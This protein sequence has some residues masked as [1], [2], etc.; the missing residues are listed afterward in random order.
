MTRT[1]IKGGTVVTATNTT[2]ADVLIEDDKIIA[3][4]GEAHGGFADTVAEAIVGTSIDRTIDATGKYVIPGAID[5]HT[6]FEL[7]FGG[8]FVSDSFETGTRAAAFGGTTSLVDFAVQ[9]KGERVMDGF[10]TWMQKAEG[11]CAIDYGFHMIVGDIN[12][13]SLKEMDAVVDEGVT[14]F[15]LFMAYP[16]VLYSDDGEIFRAMQQAAKNGTMIMMHAENGIAIDVLR[17][18][19]VVMGHTDPKYHTT[20][21]PPTTESEAAHRAL[22]LADLAGAPLYIVHMSAKE[23]VA[24]LTAARDRGQNAF[25]ETCPQYLFLNWEEHVS[26]PGFEGAKYVCSTPIRPAAEGHQEY[27]W[28]ALARG[29]LQIVSTDHADFFYDDDEVMGRQKRLGEGNF[30][31]IPNGLPGVEERLNVM[32]QGGVVEGRIGLNR[33]VELCSTNPAKM[34]GMYPKKGDIAV[35]SD[36]DIVVYDPNA[37]FTYG[38]D[39]IHGNIDYTAYDGMEVSGSPSVVMS[40]GKVIV[41]NGTYVGTKGDGQYLKRGL[42]QMLI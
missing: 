20:T 30:T 11:N 37:G 21:R 12:E 6:H 15:K 4:Y 31:L 9:V 16:G 36:A 34:F 42:S 35:G 2:K 41:D 33:W 17:D 40:R 19:A 5:I 3:I 1:V 10:E 14:S 29:D 7:P 13:E 22:I 8:T 27:L 18:Q 25:G 38:V 26:A 28:N 32:Y 23:A 24:E 39:T